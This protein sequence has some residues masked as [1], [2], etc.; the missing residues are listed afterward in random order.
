MAND[1]SGALGDDHELSVR[2]RRYANRVIADDEWPLTA[3]HVDL[4][5]VT[6]ETSTRMERK[7]GVCVADRTGHCTVRLSEKTVERAGFSAI[8]ETIRHELVHV[9]QRQVEGVEMGHGESF[10]RWVDPLGLSGRCS[11]HYTPREDE[12]AYAFHCV[13]CGFIGGRY[14]M[15]KTVRAAFDGALR[16]GLCDSRAI[17]VRDDRGTVLSGNRSQ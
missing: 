15:C 1:V 9:Y 11:N 5:R 3:E 8:K 10:K 17:E 4:D 14:R 13:H 6:F 16:C 12:Y 7:H 2:A